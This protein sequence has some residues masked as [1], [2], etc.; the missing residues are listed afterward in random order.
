MALAA[1]VYSWQW[2]FD[3]RSMEALSEHLLST[4]FGM[5]W[6]YVIYVHAFV[7]F[8]TAHD[9]EAKEWAKKDYNF[10]LNTLDVT[11]DI[12]LYLNICHLWC[13]SL[14]EYIWSTIFVIYVIYYLWTYVIYDV[15]YPQKEMSELWQ[16]LVYM[17]VR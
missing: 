15:I 6:T 13:M 3:P 1:S 7:Y 17:I 9:S 11:Y 2:R 8:S 10:F 14:F 4:M 5:I 16:V 12:C